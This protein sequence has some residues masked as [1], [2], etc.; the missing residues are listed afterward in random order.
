[1]SRPA[2]SHRAPRRL[3]ALTVAVALSL[4]S[5]SAAAQ[6][7]HRG[8]ALP[9]PRRQFDDSWFWG[10][11]GGAMRFGTMLDGRVTAPL[12]GAEWMITRHHGALLVSA[13]QSFFDRTSMVADPSVAEGARTV[14]I[15]DAR[16]YSL[17]ALA[18]PKSFGWARPYAGLGL[19]IH[20]IRQ[21]TPEGRFT[22][23]AQYDEVA[24]RVDAGQSLVAPFALVG[25][26]GQFGRFALFAQGSASGEQ[27]RSLWNRG[28]TSQV[29]AGLRYNV[30]SAFER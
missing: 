22:T 16:R 27:T 5:H 26:Q 15:K 8:V 1:M 9:D 29:E 25:V 30:S 10:A 28:G 24:D 14:S 23:Q 21:A 19:A 20:V 12:A 3:G 13:E 4:L 2:L 18:A 17:A 6:E 11:K 7:S